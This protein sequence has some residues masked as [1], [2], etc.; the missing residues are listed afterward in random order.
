VPVILE[1]FADGFRIWNPE[2]GADRPL[3]PYDIENMRYLRCI[4][5]Q[6][7]LPIDVLIY[8]Q[9]NGDIVTDNNGEFITEIRDYTQYP[10]DAVFSLRL[11]HNNTAPPTPISMQ[12][13]ILRLPHTSS[14]T[15]RASAAKKG[16]LVPSSPPSLKQR[17]R[18]R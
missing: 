16:S 17:R 12:R 18:K 4:E 8:L 1:K 14:R 3:F 11:S 2:C 15:T 9:S 6:G 5:K 7:V 10:L 13:T